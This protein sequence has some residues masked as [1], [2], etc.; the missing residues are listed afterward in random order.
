M[1][2]IYFKCACGK[3]LAV[4]E[5]GVGRTVLCADC[6]QPV[7]VPEFDIEFACEACQATLLAP[8]TVGG[9]RI[10]CVQCG[11][12]MTV[13]VMDKDQRGVFSD[14]GALADDSVEG[15]RAVKEASLEPATKRCMDT[16][17]NRHSEFLA[18][19]RPE[20]MRSGWL[21]RAALLVLALAAGAYLAQRFISERPSVLVNEDPVRTALAQ[22]AVD[23]PSA[24]PAAEDQPASQTAKLIEKPDEAVPVFSAKTRLAGRSSAISKPAIKEPGRSSEAVKAAASPAISRPTQ[25]MPARAS[26][27]AS[28]VK[29]VIHPAKQL[30]DECNEVKAVLQQ[31]PTDKKNAV[32]IGKIKKCR[33]HVL[34]YTRTH[35]GKD[36]DGWCWRNAVVGTLWL[37]SY[38]EWNSFEEADRAIREAVDILAEAEP[39]K[40]GLNIQAMFHA[41]LL[42]EQVWYRQAPER[43]AEWLDKARAL[44]FEKGDAALRKSWEFFAPSREINLIFAASIL[45]PE[46]RKKFQ[47]KRERNLTGYLRNEGIP[48]EWRTKALWWWAVNLKTVGKMEKAARLLDAWQKKYDRQ[49]E[50]PLFFEIRMLI[51]VHGDGDWGKAREMVGRMRKLVK[52]GIVPEDNWS[53]NNMTSKYYKYIL[54]PEYEIKRQYRLEMAK[55]QRRT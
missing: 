49:I 22:G 44:A 33:E 45:P 28:A 43:C 11:H 6:G 48:L 13:P 9:D 34:D 2:D 55:E 37:S 46:R 16:L 20:P 42:H 10:E 32:L 5:N 52:K 50:T 3:S 27:D 15:A 1:A 47:D 17:M 4:D 53:W 29:S 8:V 36:L 7:K 19:R 21:F 30:L 51:A 31:N 40:S 54:V 39:E 24:P 18:R 23:K 26:A 41:I 38:R 12:R 35:T 25:V 14:N